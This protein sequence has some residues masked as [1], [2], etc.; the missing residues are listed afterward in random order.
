MN[1][2]TVGVGMIGAG[3]IGRIHARNLAKRTH[4]AR[5]AAVMDVDAERAETVAAASGAG[6]VYADA[7]ALIADPEVDAVLIA[8][9]DATHAELA[10]A[11]IDAGKPVLC[12]K[13]LATIASDA[14]RVLEAELAAGR[15]LLQVG[16]MREYDPAHQD[17]VMILQSGAIGE[18]LRFRGAHINPHYGVDW[19][20]EEAIV[21]SLIHDIHSARFMMDA[22]ISSV[23]VSWVA[24]DPQRP[25]TCRLADVNL[26]FDNGA[27]GALEWNGDSGYGY[28]VQ[29]EITCESGVASTLPSDSPV[30][31][32]VGGVSQAITPSWPQR[33]ERAYVEEMQAW[34]RSIKAKEPTGPSAWDGYMTLAVAEACVRS[35]VTGLPVEIAPIERPALYG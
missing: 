34:I 1:N 30:V 16:F 11:C 14:K 10:L 33:F 35:T 2:D 26:R 24:V 4:G 12:E 15:R 23:Q 9:P 29:V 31:R 21:N 18:A 3:A 27:I 6:R 20:V 5:L 32:G 25:R 13:P 17:V 19:T 8:S 28:E 22:E 7:D